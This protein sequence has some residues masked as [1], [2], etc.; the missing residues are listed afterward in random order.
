MV[1]VIKPRRV[2]VLKDKLL[3]LPYELCIERIKFFTEVYKENS[4]DPE[5]LKRAKA[6]AKTLQNMTIFICKDL[7]FNV[8]R[9][10][11][12]FLDINIGVSKISLCLCL[13]G[14]KA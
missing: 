7:Y 8:T 14:H 5:I 3:R 1:Q 13:G 12:I 10:L 4:N 11:D 6:L 9:F 2:Q